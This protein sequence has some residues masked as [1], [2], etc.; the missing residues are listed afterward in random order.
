[1]LEAWSR[2]VSVEMNVSGSERYIPVVDLAEFEGKYVTKGSRSHWGPVFG[3]L[4]ALKA[5]KKQP[6]CLVNNDTAVLLMG[7]M[8]AL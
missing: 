8:W 1:M 2:V 4:S 3:L 7:R 6:V 5:K